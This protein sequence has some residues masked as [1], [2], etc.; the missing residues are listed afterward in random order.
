[1][2]NMPESVLGAF[3]LLQNGVFVRQL[4]SPTPL[5]PDTTFDIFIVDSR[6]F[7]TLVTTD[8]VDLY[9]QSHELK[10]ISGQYKFVFT[11]LVK[12]FN[13]EK[14]IKVLS[15]DEMDGSFFVTATHKKSQLYYYLAA[16]KTGSVSELVLPS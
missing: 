2:N 16:L 5:V 7:F 3:P 12:P 13:N 11:H 9:N 4:A 15:N 6:S 10:N 14:T 1:M 8:Y